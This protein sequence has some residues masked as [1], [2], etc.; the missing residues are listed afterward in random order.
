MSYLGWLKITASRPVS[1]RKALPRGAAGCDPN[2]WCAPCVSGGAAQA[3]TRP[4]SRGLHGRFSSGTRGSGG[5][6]F[7]WVWGMGAGT[8]R[9]LGSKSQAG[10]D[11]NESALGCGVGRGARV[12]AKEPKRTGRP[13]PLCIGAPLQLAH[14][15]P[16]NRCSRRSCRRH[17]VELEWFVLPISLFG[18]Q[19][20]P[21]WGRRAACAPPRAASREKVREFLRTSRHIKTRIEV[22]AA[23][24]GPELPQGQCAASGEPF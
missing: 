6:G 18:G 15:P 23:A 14:P 24:L 10:W 11:W 8:R 3:R 22:I 12:R 19:Q 16:P 21:H 2:A 1:V 13:L 17:V 20:A 4:Q 7:P 9:E 5:C